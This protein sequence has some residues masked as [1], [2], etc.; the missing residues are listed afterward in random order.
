MPAS[1]STY[2]RER[3]DAEAHR[4]PSDFRV[5]IEEG[6]Q[7]GAQLFF[8]VIFAAFEQVHGDVGGATVF[9]F[10]VGIADFEEFVGGQEAHSVNQSKVG[11]GDS[12]RFTVGGLKSAVES[13][14]HRSFATLR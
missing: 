11:H 5:K 14:M 4:E 12:L 10:D 3:E 8:D 6:F 1:A 2:H 7:A 9:E 13:G